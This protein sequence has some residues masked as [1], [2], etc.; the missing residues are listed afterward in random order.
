MIQG[1][2]SISQDLRPVVLERLGL[3][4][5]VKSMVVTVNELKVVTATFEDISRKT[6]SKENELNVYR[7]LQELINNT[8][9]HANAT[10]ISILFKNELANFVIVYQDNGIGF[11]QEI[12]PQK[13]GIGLK[14]IESRLSILSGKLSYENVPKGI[15]LTLL[16]PV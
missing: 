16:I 12:L 7:I 10:E 11:Q 6:V 14:N 4:E 2:R 9:K 13:K 3:S 1:V 15:K 5:A 8:L